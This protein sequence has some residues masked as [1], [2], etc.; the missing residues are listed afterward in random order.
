MDL[1]TRSELAAVR[2][3]EIFAKIAE[4]SERM[5]HLQEDLDRLATL[6]EEV[7]RSHHL[8]PIGH[9]MK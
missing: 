7:L 4:Q 6:I 3:E 1:Q 9:K 2:V 5:R 8:E